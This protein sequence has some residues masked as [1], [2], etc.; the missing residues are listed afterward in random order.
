[1]SNKKSKGNGISEAELRL[2]DEDGLEET[3]LKTDKSAEP[4]TE[5]EDEDLGVELVSMIAAGD[6]GSYLNEN[7]TLY[8]NDVL[9]DRI[10]HDK[11]DELG[12]SFRSKDLSEADLTE[13]E[14]MPILED[15]WIENESSGPNLGWLK[16]LIIVGVLLV[17]SASIWSFISL[18][19]EDV[20][21][22]SRAGELKN[23]ALMSEQ[24]DSEYYE[25]QKSVL[26]CVESYLE[27]ISIEQRVKYCRNPKSTLRKMT[28]HYNK[29]STFD[30]YQ[31]ERIAESSEIKIAGKNVTIV[32]VYV[33]SN[34]GEVIAK[35]N[36]KSLLLEKQ[37]DGSYLVDWETAVVYQPADLSEFIT[38]RSSEP[39][40][41]RV[42]VI[43]MIGYGPYLYTFSDDKKYQAFR[44]NIRGD[45]VN[46]LIGYTKK[47]SEVDKRM[48]MVTVSNSNNDRSSKST[49]PMMLKLVFPK[50]SKSNQCV[51]I[52][53]VVSDS[54]FLP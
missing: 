53:E 17:T 19:N 51:E 38:G 41:F 37:E 54:W 21:A 36:R 42:D 47:G 27:A 3:S 28:E 6:S 23:I 5:D 39:H 8:Q 32:G 14:A 31:L 4:L 13:R 7:T 16:K 12:R 52:I 11:D 49:V 34:S 30:T 33:S 2:A 24:S 26:E 29:A 35:N 22:E 40:T 48:K 9:V 25:S 43:G 45:D 44:L 50:D 20:A 18:G 46:Y 10:E 15:Q 1:M